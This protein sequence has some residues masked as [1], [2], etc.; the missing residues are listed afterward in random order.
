MDSDFVD[1]DRDRAIILSAGVIGGSE[2]VRKTVRS[3]AVTYLLHHQTVNENHEL[4][5]AF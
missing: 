5:G 1:C 2:C 3:S 4:D